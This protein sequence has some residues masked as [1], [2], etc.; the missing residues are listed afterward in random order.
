MFTGGYLSSRVGLSLT[1]TAGLPDARVTSLK[2]YA[3]RL[4]ALSTPRRRAAPWRLADARRTPASAAGR[5]ARAAGRDH[6]LSGG[7]GGGAVYGTFSLSG[8]DFQST[9]ADSTRRPRPAAAAG[10]AS[11]RTSVQAAEEGEG[12]G[13]EEDDEPHDSSREVDEL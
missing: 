10:A 1:T 11:V 4:H 8:L 5:D 2:E 7:A 6:P 3:D 9:L 12:P 13:G